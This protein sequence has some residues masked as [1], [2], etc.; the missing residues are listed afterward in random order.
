MRFLA[1]EHSTRHSLRLRG[2]HAENELGLKDNMRRHRL[3]NPTSLQ[4]EQ[5]RQTYSD[6]DNILDD[7][8]EFIDKNIEKKS[9]YDWLSTAWTSKSAN[10]EPTPVR[11]TNGD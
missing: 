1:D 3:K 9:F 10:D 4:D 6:D 7:D 11:I 2:F 8:L 5:L